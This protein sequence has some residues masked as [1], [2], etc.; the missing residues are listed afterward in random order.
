MQNKMRPPDVS[1]SVVK[2]VSVK[3]DTVVTTTMPRKETLTNSFVCPAE[4]RTR[5]NPANIRQIANVIWYVPRGT[6]IM[7]VSGSAMRILTVTQQMVKSVA[8][9]SDTDSKSV[10]QLDNESMVK[11]PYSV[12]E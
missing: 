7:N 10:Q 5:E 12:G 9:L 2:A 6:D 4:I 8:L 1:R 3:T 11:S